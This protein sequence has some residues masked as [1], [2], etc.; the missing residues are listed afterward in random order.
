MQYQYYD[1]RAPHHDYDHKQALAW[2]ETLELHE[3]V[4]FQ[5]V[6][7]MKLKHT[8][9]KIDCETLKGIYQQGIRG[10][11][12]NIKELLPLYGRTPRPGQS[13]EYRKDAAKMKTEDMDRMFYAGELLNFAKAGVRNFAV[14][15]T[16][17]ATPALRAVFVKQMQQAIQLHA[18]I[19]NYMYE[20]SFY[21]S[22]NLDQLLTN[23][24]NLAQKALS[25]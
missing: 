9:N 24:V 4:A 16:E 10:L 21:P 14:V 19:F 6:G 5:S 15:I 20:R 11:E 22:Y 18:A 12:A 8:V 25:M 23:D 1:A 7:L 17:T 13:S 2:H 3:I